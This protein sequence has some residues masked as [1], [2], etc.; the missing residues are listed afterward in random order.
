MAA[1]RDLGP[2]PDP[3]EA[4]RTT[5][6]LESNIHFRR[7]EL[8]LATDINPG[9]AP[10]PSTTSV[11]AAAPGAARSLTAYQ[12]VHTGQPVGTEISPIAEVD[13]LQQLQRPLLARPRGGVGEHHR[14]F[15][16]LAPERR[17]DVF[18]GHAARGEGP[19]HAGKGL[20]AAHRVV[21]TPAVDVDVDEVGDVLGVVAEVGDRLTGRPDRLSG[22]GTTA[23]HSG[24]R[25]TGRGGDEPGP[26]GE[27]TDPGSDG[28]PGDDIDR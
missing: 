19:S 26:A 21:P 23:R 14:Q 16:V 9:S 12:G 5:Y 2:D 11:S 20:A 6:L 15:H 7:G 28:C 24:G 3:D 22:V 27:S 25:S 17:G 13:H 8:A 18:R 10:C 4:V 1:R